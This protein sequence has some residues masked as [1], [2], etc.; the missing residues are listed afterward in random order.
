MAEEN[1]DRDLDI[2]HILQDIQ[3]DKAKR[4][5]ETPAD[6]HEELLSR[7]RQAKVS[8]FK[9]DLDLDGEYGGAPSQ[10]EPPPVRG[11]AAT[12]RRFLWRRCP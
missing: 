10:S 12:R 6:S 8:G 11:T 4:E 1:K 5:Q 2:D 7:E 9:L 3:A